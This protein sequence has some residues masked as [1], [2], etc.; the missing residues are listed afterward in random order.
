MKANLIRVAVSNYLSIRNKQEIFFTAETKY[1]SGKDHKKWNLIKLGDNKINPV[2]PV[3]VFYGA[4]GSGKSNLL[5]AMGIVGNFLGRANQS[6]SPIATQPFA[7]DTDKPSSFEYDFSI[8]GEVYSFEFE[9]NK[10][11]FTEET[12]GILKNGKMEQIYD[13][14][15]GFL[16]ET[17]IPEQARKNIK[18][19]LATRRDFLILDALTPRGLQP[20]VKISTFFGKER[21]RR[22]TPTYLAERLYE[23]NELKA[24]VE[25][26]LQMADVGIESIEIEKINTAKLSPPIGN[27]IEDIVDVLIR[28]EISKKFANA[29]G[30]DTSVFIMKFKHKSE[31]LPFS[32]NYQMESSGTKTFLEYI[33]NLLVAFSDGEVFIVDELEESLH[34]ML[35][36]KIIEM[37]HN[38]AINKAG[39]QLIFTTHE[40]NL[41][42]PELLRR[43]EIWFVEKS[44]V[45]ES[46]TYPLSDFTDIRNNCNYERGYLEGRFGAIPYLSSF[47]Q[48]IQIFEE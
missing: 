29:D 24:K 10:N 7:L 22:K 46:I 31:G 42:K 3:T 35:L 37:F 11:G 1:A 25:T 6:P 26:Y 48:L 8:D 13:R 12:L 34:P 20:F 33:T 41:M 9:Y 38:P 14:Q 44:E 21:A 32:V 28:R 2:L 19:L 40:T 16:D 4:N 36:T 17:I 15:T 30:D 47:D 43:D 45:G 5:L 39:A 27:N 23:N 18:E